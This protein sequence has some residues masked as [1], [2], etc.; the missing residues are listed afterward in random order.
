MRYS[1]FSD[2]IWMNE[3]SF[4]NSKLI[5]FRFQTQFATTQLCF[6]VLRPRW[7]TGRSNRALQGPP[8]PWQVHRFQHDLRDV[9]IPFVPSSV[10]AAQCISSRP[11]P[12]LPK[13]G[14]HGYIIRGIIPF[15]GPTIQVSE[16][17]VH[18]PR[19]LFVIITMLLILSL[20]V[21]YHFA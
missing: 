18:L 15:Y 21:E 1:I 8:T 2:P 19:L 11:K 14:N 4:Q 5:P 13:P 9:Y 16:I 17:L 7:K 3:K 12:V 6:S 10:S 20:I